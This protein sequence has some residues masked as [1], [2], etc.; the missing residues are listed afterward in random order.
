MDEEIYEGDKYELWIQDPEVGYWLQLSTH[1]P[2]YKFERIERRDYWDPFR[3]LL[4]WLNL[5][6]PCPLWYEYNKVMIESDVEFRIRMYQT[7]QKIKT[8]SNHRVK[9][10]QWCSDGDGNFWK[11][12]INTDGE[13]L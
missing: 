11:E 13:W 5:I 9:L 12:L 1:S 2:K 4:S 3:T 6:Q 8:S 10:Y 7:I